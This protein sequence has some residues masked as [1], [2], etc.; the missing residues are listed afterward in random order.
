MSEPMDCECSTWA[1]ADMRTED[2]VNHHPKCPHR[3]THDGVRILCLKA[4]TAMSDWGSLED[5]VPEEAWDVY[6]QLRMM[7]G[8]PQAEKG[9]Q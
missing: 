2:F 3:H 1:R 7:G 5:G 9:S 8:L 6:Q 4:A